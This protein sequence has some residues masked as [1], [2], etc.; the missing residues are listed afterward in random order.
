MEWEIWEFLRSYNLSD[1]SEFLLQNPW[2]FFSC[3]KICDLFFRF[4]L[5]IYLFLLIYA[6][7]YTGL[8]IFFRWKKKWIWGNHPMW[9]WL[10]F[11]IGL[12]RW[13]NEAWILYKYSV[14]L[15]NSYIPT[16]R[17][18]AAYWRFTL[19][20]AIFILILSLS[21]FCVCFA[22]RFKITSFLFLSLIFS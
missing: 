17:T 6:Y 12:H 16:A 7:I 21:F 8:C 19:P 22:F 18:I 15:L 9:N 3:W 5:P 4:F 20:F 1:S 2:P 11:N 10:E 14:T 13:V